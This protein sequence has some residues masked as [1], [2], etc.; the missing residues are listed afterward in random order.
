MNLPSWHQARYLLV[1]ILCAGV[2]N[3]IVIGG[4]ALGVHY[5]VSV[6]VSYCVVVVLGYLLHVHFTFDREPS[7]GSFGR[8]AVGM[9]A[10]WP[11]TVALLFVFC[12][13]LHLPM[14]IASPVVT[15]IMI[16]WNYAVSRW[17]ITSRMLGLK[18]RGGLA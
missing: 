13:L 7:L 14:F 18:P 16:V 12:D 5:A 2:H 8:Y 10:N 1:G 6:T 9:L 17:A 3:A 4:A 11:F 15:V